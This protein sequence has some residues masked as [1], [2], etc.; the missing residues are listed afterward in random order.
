MGTRKFILPSPV[1]Q[2][3][4]LERSEAVW[5]CDV[6]CDTLKIVRLST[7]SPAIRLLCLVDITFLPRAALQNEVLVNSSWAFIR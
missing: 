4:G 1:T 3:Q 5:T 6:I 7:A 2:W